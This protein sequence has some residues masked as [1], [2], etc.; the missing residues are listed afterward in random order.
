MSC[1]RGEIYIFSCLNTSALHVAG[2]RG[3]LEK[4]IFACYQLLKIVEDKLKV[5]IALVYHLVNMPKED[6]AN[7]ELR[8]VVTYAA[9]LSGLR[10]ACR[11]SNGMEKLLEM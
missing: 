11:S 2:Q 7:V 10:R 8:V 1:R 3:K 6:G 5:H 4:K 9:I